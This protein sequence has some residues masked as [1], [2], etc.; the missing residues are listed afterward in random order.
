MTVNGIVSYQIGSNG[1][2]G[3]RTEH[4]GASFGTAPAVGVETAAGDVVLADPGQ[5]GF[6]AFGFFSGGRLDSLGAVRDTASTHADSV[7]AMAAVRVG[8]NDIVIVASQSEYG[9]TAYQMGGGRPVAGD[10]VGPA[11]GIGI[12]VP[13][14]IAVAQTGGGT[15]VIVASEPSRGESGALS[16]LRVDGRGGLEP[17]DHVLDT[18]DSRFGNVQQV[19]TVTHDGHTYVVAAGGDG[20][21]SLFELMPNGR[22]VHLHSIAGTVDHELGDITAL[23]IAVVG[24]ELQVFVATEGDPGITVLTAEI[25]GRGRALVAGE[26][27]ERLVGTGRDDILVDGEGR[28]RLEGRGGADRYVLT[29]DGGCEDRIPPG[30]EVYALVTLSPLDGRPGVSRRTKPF[31]IGD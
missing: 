17:V 11:Q 10:S 9:V 12:M 6:A 3:D 22:L 29:E 4:R 18:R 1:N 8:G 24:D 16:V 2:I 25:D 13:T 28:D 19:E 21:L 27:G 15:F 14:D 5:S 7:G 20:G 31:T 26:G 30:V 23:E